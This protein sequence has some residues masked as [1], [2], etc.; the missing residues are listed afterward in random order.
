M[1]LR[2][3]RRAIVR[4]T[5]RVAELEPRPERRCVARTE[6]FGI[7]PVA[8]DEHA[9]GARSEV[10]R[11]AGRVAASG[12]HA[13]RLRE[14]SPSHAVVAAL[15][16]AD[17]SPGSEQELA[18]VR[19]DRDLFDF[20]ET[21][22]GA[23][24]GRRAPLRVQR[25]IEPFSRGESRESR[26]AREHQGVRGSGADHAKA[27]RGVRRLAVFGGRSDHRELFA[28][29]RQPARHFERPGLDPTASG[30]KVLGHEHETHE[31]GL[32]A[33]TRLRDS[34]SRHG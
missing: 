11:E 23:S 21:P 20:S 27:E 26:C 30:W 18:A 34:E 15:R 16:C 5:G 19:R 8:R 12:E 14:L 17:P 7:R 10:S 33:A 3:T 29:A 25:S 6:A 1:P 31:S 24:R 2:G 13:I 32:M 9:F 4:S 28:A 22:Q